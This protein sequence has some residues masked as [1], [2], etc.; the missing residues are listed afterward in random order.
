MIVF[1]RLGESTSS[2]LD[3]EI[4][5]N[6]QIQYVQFAFSQ[7]LKMNE[8]KQEELTAFDVPCILATMKLSS[9]NNSAHN[10]D[11]SN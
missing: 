10:N 6:I 9:S 5:H 1:L 4:F 11:N 2:I 7:K 8:L 3:S